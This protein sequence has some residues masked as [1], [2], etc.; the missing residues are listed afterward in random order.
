M[1]LI[2]ISGQLHIATSLLPIHVLIDTDC[3]QTNVVSARIAAALRK[4]GGEIQKASI[5][6]TSGVGGR[7]YG[8]ERVMNVTV[9]LKSRVLGVRKQTCLR[10][11]VCKDVTTDLII[12]IP[13]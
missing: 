10:V 9:S 2:L 6:L 5:T 13:L 1:N 7:W 3:T 8:V 4:E 11:L 12:G